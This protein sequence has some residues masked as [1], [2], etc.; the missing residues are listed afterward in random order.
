MAPG[1]RLAGR[2][3]DTRRGLSPRKSRR[4]AVWDCGC[5]VACSRSLGSGA[6]ETSSVPALPVTGG[7]TT[8]ASERSC[9]LPLAE[10]ELGHA[11][12]HGF[13]MSHGRG[14]THCTLTP[15]AHPSVTLHPG[16]Q[17]T[18][19]A[20]LTQGARA[21]CSRPRPL[22]TLSPPA[23]HPACRAARSL[24][25]TESGH[26]G[27]CPSRRVGHLGRDVGGLLRLPRRGLCAVQL[28]DLAPSTR[29][30]PRE[31]KR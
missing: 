28:P 1:G 16:C 15:A 26:A 9:V 18:L 8:R 25:I 22:A 19:H 21:V 20:L 6:A 3:V 5:C 24:C 13:T 11:L 30:H 27:F 23:A 14:Q 31:G 12:L 2:A 17:G 10:W 7:V 29:A 4:V